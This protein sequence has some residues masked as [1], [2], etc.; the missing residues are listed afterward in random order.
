MKSKLTYEESIKK[1]QEIID[2]LQNDKYNME[3]MGNALTTAKEIITNCEKSLRDIQDKL[4][5]INT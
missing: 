3:E 5:D 4:N 2:N 1:L